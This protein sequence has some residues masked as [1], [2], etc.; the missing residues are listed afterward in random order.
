MC[1][2]SKPGNRCATTTPSWASL[3]KA[4]SLLEL[5]CLGWKVVTGLFASL[6]NR[7]ERPEFTSVTWPQIAK[8][9]ISGRNQW[10]GP[11]G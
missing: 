6:R 4:G 9:I 7:K 8:T 1:G 11:L 5:M 3:L 2:T 10:H